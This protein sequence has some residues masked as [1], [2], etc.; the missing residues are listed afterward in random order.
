M[1]QWYG[2]KW[3]ERW[4]YGT[5]LHAGATQGAK[6]LPAL[7]ALAEDAGTPPIVQATAATLAQPYIRPGSLPAVR[8]LLANAAP[9]VRIAALGLI[10]PFEPAARAQ[11]AAPIR[12]AA[13]ASRPR[14][15]SRMSVTIS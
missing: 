11:A 6:A 8:R 4:H 12:C 9:A 14:A 13:C 7:L 15:S 10:E 2:K 1:D 5:T 3:R